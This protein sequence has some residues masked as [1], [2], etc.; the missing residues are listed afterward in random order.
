V[1][2]GVD[3]DEDGQIDEGIA[4]LSCGEGAC[5]VVV[6]GCIDGRVPTCTPGVPSPEVCN[7]RDDDCDGA[8]DEG[9]FM[10]PLAGPTP[11][12]DEAFQ[13]RGLPATP[14]G[15]LLTWFKSFNGSSPEP[16][17]FAMP[18][19]DLGAPA[20]EQVR[21]V[22]PP[23]VLGPTLAPSLEGRFVAGTCRRFGF[24]TF[25]TWLKLDASGQVIAEEHRVSS[26]VECVTSGTDPQLLW[27]GERH[28][29]A[30]MNSQTDAQV[31]L[32]V[33]DAEGGGATTRTVID[34]GD[35]SVPPRWL[36]HDGR[37]ALIAG[38]RPP[39][40]TSS[41][42]RVLFMDAGGDEVAAPLELV[43]PDG[44]YFYQMKAAVDDEGV[45]TIVSGT[46]TG[47]VG[48]V[49]AAVD[50][51]GEVLA[52]VTAI[53]SLDDASPSAL[54][55]REGGGVWLVTVYASGQGLLNG[56]D[57]LQ[58]EAEVLPLAGPIIGYPVVASHRGRVTV[59]YTAIDDDSL[60]YTLW[61]ETFG[62]A[63]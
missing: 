16:S 10:E 3:D 41:G 24:S 9:L 29:F 43:P 60:Q 37:V 59:V 51:N 54:S 45:V 31:M 30:W 35:L 25:P 63:L 7:Q 13:G 49:W 48:V 53:P 62:C 40:G 42:L 26:S 56:I 5:R 47:G 61:S 18:L 1:C 27:T 14:N 52:P 50:M 32:E 46:N 33:S 4:D 19:D 17:G 28:L 44:I 38:T 57:F 55:A 15:L 36:Q 20:G 39:G 34:D 22:E 23:V 58:S 21:L 12:V 2:N 11:L 6:A 8:V